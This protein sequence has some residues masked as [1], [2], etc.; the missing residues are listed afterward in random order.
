MGLELVPPME[1]EMRA[2][3]RT[4]RRLAVR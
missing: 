2:S 4:F 1:T 3:V